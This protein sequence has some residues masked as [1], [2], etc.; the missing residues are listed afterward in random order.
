MDPDIWQLTN[1]RR[2]RASPPM[3]GQPEATRYQRGRGWDYGSAYRIALTRRPSI[4][5]LR[6]LQL[7]RPSLVNSQRLLDNFNLAS[8]SSLIC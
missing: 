8:L 6:T 2:V 1:Q 4:L 5:S 7:S 3:A